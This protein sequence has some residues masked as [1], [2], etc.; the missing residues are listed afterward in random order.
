M[1]VGDLISVLEE[2]RDVILGAGPMQRSGGRANGRMWASVLCLHH[3]PL[4]RR[5]EKDSLS[6]FTRN[7]ASKCPKCDKTVY[8][9]ECVSST[10]VASF[11]L[12]ASTQRRRYEGDVLTSGDGADGRFHEIYRRHMS[13]VCDVILTSKPVVEGR[14]RSGLFYRCGSAENGNIVTSHP[15]RLKN[16]KGQGDI[17]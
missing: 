8:F 2:R 5:T 9:G 11:I 1:N 7:M 12:R 6:S 14:T 10:R 15:R 17:F 13:S 4:R 3:H 16:S